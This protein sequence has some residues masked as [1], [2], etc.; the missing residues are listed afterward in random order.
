MG[1]LIGIEEF[2]SKDQVGINPSWYFPDAFWQSGW[3]FTIASGFP[4]EVGVHQDH[5]DGSDA[6]PGLRVTIRR[7]I[8]ANISG[9]VIHSKRRLDYYRVIFDDGD[10][11]RAWY[12][13]IRHGYTVF[14]FET[15]N[16]ALLFRLA[17]ADHASEI[18]LR[19]PGYPPGDHT[20]DVDNQWEAQRL[21]P[22]YRRRLW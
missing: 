17:H 20:Q 2:A 12:Y 1:R 13:D 18:S 6:V 3:I 5:I 4:Y 16:D 10:K 22:D 7:W 15:E 8:E 19:H 21:A 11:E 14:S 9:T